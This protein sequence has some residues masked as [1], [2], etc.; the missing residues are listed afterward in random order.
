MPRHHAVVAQ[1][2]ALWRPDDPRAINDVRRNLLDCYAE[3]TLEVISALVKH[4]ACAREAIEALLKTPTIKAHVAEI[5]WKLGQLGFDVRT[6]EQIAEEARQRVA[7]KEWAVRSLMTRYNREKLYEDAWSEP[8]SKLAKRYGVSDVMLTK[9][10]R[11]LSIPKPGRGYWEKKAA[12]K[13]VPKRPAL[14]PL[15]FK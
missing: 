8:M 1:R 6:R 14:P 3:V 15:N 12:G 4:N 2:G 13:P 9:V 5:K 11:K 10:C 7:A